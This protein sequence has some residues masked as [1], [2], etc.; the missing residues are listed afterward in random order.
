LN[1]TWQAKYLNKIVH[2]DC[3]NL[4]K[5]IPTGT[6]DLIIADPPYYKVVGQKWDYLWRTLEDYLDWSL[7]WIRESSRVLRLGGSLYFFGYIRILAHIIPKLEELGL[8]FKQQIIIDKGMQAVSGRA[9]K[10]YTIFPNTT[11]SILLIIKDNKQWL[12]EFLKEKQMQKGWSSKQI[13]EKL[14]VK[15]NGGGMWSIYT[16]KNICE[17][18][19]TKERWSQFERIFEFSLDYQKVSQTFNP[20]MGFTNVWTDIDFYNVKRIHPTQKPLKLIQRL[21]QASSHQY[22]LILDPFMGS[23]TTA[24][25][26]KIL[27]RNYL[28][29]EINESYVRHINSRL[30]NFNFEINSVKKH[31]IP[32]DKFL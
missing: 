13:N 20:I 11:E 30:K 7:E 12:K 9:T 23:G 22:D 6:I 18:F 17:Q 32:L 5:D 24:V 27:N 29:F 14:G 28:G 21:I 8:E 4:L 16:G 2:G 26:S 15:T 31:D 3:N 25:A 19:P 1:K 10:N